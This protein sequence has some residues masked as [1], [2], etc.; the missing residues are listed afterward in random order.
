MIKLDTIKQLFKNF[1]FTISTQIQSLKCKKQH[2]VE[3]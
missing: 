1:V 3:Q 2:N